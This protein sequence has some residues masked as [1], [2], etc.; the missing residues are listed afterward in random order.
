MNKQAMCDCC[1]PVAAPSADESQV[2]RCPFVQCGAHWHRRPGSD[3]PAA[4]S[5]LQE[6]CQTATHLHTCDFLTTRATLFLN[7]SGFSLHS[8]AASMFA[9]DSSLGDESIEMMEIMMVSTCAQSRIHGLL[10]QSSLPPCIP[11]GWPAERCCGTLAMLPRLAARARSLYTTEC[12]I[13]A[14]V[15]APTALETTA[16]PLTRS[17]EGLPRGCGGWRCRPCHP[18]R[19]RTRKSK[20]RT[21]EI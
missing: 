20:R 6:Q 11:C 2:L 1:K 3:T 14:R 18:G 4:T 7:A 13:T 9:G 5:R 15:H 12:V 10:L 16:Q 21:P 8:L 19:L 17:R